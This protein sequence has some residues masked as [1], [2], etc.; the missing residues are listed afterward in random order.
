MSFMVDFDL[1]RLAVALIPN[2]VSHSSNYN[3]DLLQNILKETFELEISLFAKLVPSDTTDSA[4]AVARFFSPRAVQVDCE[5]HQLNSCLKYGFGICEN[6]KSED[7]LDD[8]GVVVQNSSGKK[9]VRKVIVTPGQSFLEGEALVK[10][11]KALANYFY[12][13]FDS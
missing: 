10:E 8:N 12:S 11:L 2:N 9:V 1:Y 7:R 13:P 6:Y 4:T 3:A 5:M